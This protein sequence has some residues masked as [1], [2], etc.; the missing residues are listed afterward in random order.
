MTGAFDTSREHELALTEAER[1]NMV[2]IR[3]IKSPPEWRDLLDELLNEGD[4]EG[5]TW[6]C[7]VDLNDRLR[8]VAFAK[9]GK[10]CWFSIFLEVEVFQKL[11][12]VDGVY[13]LARNDLAPPGTF[14]TVDR[15]FSRRGVDHGGVVEIMPDKS[16]HFLGYKAIEDKDP[17]AMWRLT[18]KLSLEMA[19]VLALQK[20]TQLCI[21]TRY[22]SEAKVQIH[23]LMVKDTAQ[24]KGLEWKFMQRQRALKG[25]PQY[26][27]VDDRTFYVTDFPR[28]ESAFAPLQDAHIE[29]LKTADLASQGRRCTVV[30]LPEDCDP[31][32]LTALLLNRGF[33][34]EEEPTVIASKFK[35]GTSIAFVKFETEEQAFNAIMDAPTMRLSGRTMVIKPTQPKAQRP[36][37]KVAA[38]EQARLEK[39]GPS[40]GMSEN[41]IK[42]LLDTM[43]KAS[44]A[45]LTEFRKQFLVDQTGTFAN[46][47]VNSIRDEIES[48]KAEVMQVKEEVLSAIEE[49]ES[50]MSTEAESQLTRHNDVT[51]SIADLAQSQGNSAKTLSKD[52]KSIVTIMKRSEVT[53]SNEMEQI[54]TRLDMLQEAIIALT[55]LKISETPEKKPPAPMAPPQDSDDSDDSDET[56][57]RYGNDESQRP[58]SNIREL[59]LT[60]SMV[61][62]PNQL[63]HVIL[64]KGLTAEE[65]ILLVQ[66][67]NRI[68]PPTHTFQWCETVQELLALG[69]E[70]LKRL[71][72]LATKNNGKGKKGKEAT[73]VLTALGKIARSTTG[74]LGQSSKENHEPGLTQI[75]PET[76]PKPTKRSAD[77]A[78]SGSEIDGDEMDRAD[79]KAAVRARTS[80][81]PGSTS[82]EELP[83]C[84]IEEALDHIA[85]LQGCYPEH[86][87]FVGLSQG[88]DTTL[89]A[90]GNKARRILMDETP[91]SSQ[92]SEDTERKRNQQQAVKHLRK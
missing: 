89:I 17:V 14:A 91:E 82:S 48:V 42:A 26:F 24:S 40:D 90:R 60:G 44:E 74:A 19:K 11:K 23:T 88:D 6:D 62:F 67:R 56:T 32:R 65:C 9:S 61:E 30:D 12:F 3:V 86:E 29:D 71:Q 47:M 4:C 68:E 39:L 70:A 55:G 59:T 20:D 34:L 15:I 83:D 43:Q 78:V 45:H 41:Q 38:D 28:A 35:P 5:N 36:L 10:S 66:A 21:R 77:Q 7:D 22:R 63:S 16:K 73:R 57:L 8:V 50:C 58:G 27:V 72:A 18:Y 2:A 84:T 76:P 49:L 79:G 54:N 52:L 92:N 51:E 31:A 75:V 46:S 1:R 64:G 69:T 53:S 87:P 81:T 33:T 85:F 13:D 80:R 37:S 25:M